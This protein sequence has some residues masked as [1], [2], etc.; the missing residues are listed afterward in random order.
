[1]TVIA[2]CSAKGA[3]GVTTLACALA[4]VWP[5]DRMIT[6]AECD[7]SGGDLAARF[8][9]S[10]KQGMASLALECRSLPEPGAVHFRRHL[11]TLPGGL[12]VLAG[13]SGASAARTVDAEV[14]KVLDLLICDG[15]AHESR[16]EDLILDCGRIQP[17]AVGQVAALAVADLALVVTRPTAEAVSSTRWIAELLSRSQRRVGAVATPDYE[18]E[19]PSFRRTEVG[20]HP[21]TQPMARLVL[22]GDGPVSAL[23][24]AATLKLELA[25]AIPTDNT[26]AAWL[27]GEA[28]RQW[29][30]AASPLVRSANA[31]VAAHLRT[32]GNSNPPSIEE[33]EPPDRRLTDFS[34]EEL[35]D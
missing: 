24:A 28:V 22:Q 17:G 23:E 33:G 27:R 29:R 7:P 15:A 9:I 35:H 30:V 6:L 5:R 14:P 31:I 19:S 16:A 26:G 21:S 2:L 13:P 18:S 20:S 3:P 32:E 10:A 8:G 34:S 12:E 1:V 4:A 11:Q 25:A